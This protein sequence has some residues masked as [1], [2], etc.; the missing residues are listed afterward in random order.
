MKMAE[1]ARRKEAGM[2]IILPEKV[3]AI[4]EQLEVHGFEGY[5]V[6]GCVRDTVLGRTPCD[7]DITTSAS[8]QQVK[9]IFPQ[10]FDTGIE[11]G[12][13]TVLMGKEGFEV[14]TYRIDGEYDDARHPR[15]VTFTANLTEDLRR[16]DFTINAM[17]Y[18]ERDGLVDVFGG[19]EDLKNG[20]VR[21]VGEPKER[22]GEDALR[23]MRAVRFCAQLGFTLEE[24]TAEAIRELAPTLKKISAERVQAELVKL[25]VSPHPDWIRQAWETGITAV[26]LPELDRM[27]EQPQ[28]SFHHIYSVGEHTLRALEQIPSD[29]VLRLA[30]LF[31]DMGKPEI[32]TQDEK[33]I[34][35]FKGHA[36]CSAVTAK[37]IMKRLKFDNDTSAKVYRLV[38]NHSLYPELTPEGVRRAVFQIGEDLFE[39]FLQVK[40]ADVLGQNPAVHQTK[41]LYIEQVQA[42]YQEILDR[43]DCLSLKRL[44][45]T[46]SDLIGDGMK[47]GKGLG[48][49]LAALLDE[50]LTDP[51]KNDREYLLNRSRKL[52][53]D[54]ECIQR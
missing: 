7:W 27:M 51:D 2:R 43:G 11:H 20:I 13:I 54:K 18:N 16:R 49:M 31:H 15:E 29:K 32:V 24:R 9:R 52:R 37:K 6:G 4:L 34:Y 33:G 21:C 10:T 14:T 8:P 5:A 19:T 47:P 22:F 40:R 39:A 28:N 17:A 25:L 30:M 36:A 45:V 3:K 35:H 41:L 1:Y 26:I 46:G 48:E 42:L 38:L 44:A 50:V 53:R 12:T 23:M